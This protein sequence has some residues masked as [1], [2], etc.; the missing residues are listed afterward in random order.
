METISVAIITD[1]R[2]YGRALSLSI[3]SVC[4]NFM[5]DVFCKSREDCGAI[6]DSHDLVL[7]DGSDE[8]A[9]K[10]NLVFLTEKPSMVINDFSQKK[11]RIYKYA[12]AQSAVSSIFRIYSAMTGRRMVN[13]RSREVK[14][15]VFSSWSGG[16][17]CSTL[18]LATGQELS[19]FRGKK[20]MYLS[21]EELESTGDYFES[22]GGVR[23]A[24]RYLY[25][26]LKEKESQGQTSV[27]EPL[28]CSPFLEGYVLK[29]DFGMETFAPT[30]G[31]NPLKDVTT[32]ELY[33]LLSSLIDSGRYDVILMDLGNCLSKVSLSCIEMAERLCVVTAG[34]KEDS[35]E[36]RYF[37]HLI[38]SCGESVLEKTVRAVN[39]SPLRESGAEGDS[40]AGESAED[41]FVCGETLFIAKSPG[42]CMESGIRKISL[43]GAFG[44][45]IN[46]LA[47]SMTEPTDAE[48]TKEGP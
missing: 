33:L 19:R 47:K 16:A 27:M 26:L 3:L 11:Y 12:S 7:Y 43:E 10:S 45:S 30:R 44:E 21:F 14:L 46:R 32:E 25:H 31:R 1:D 2:E 9:G 28:R 35:R 13:V 48:Q 29:D 34:E 17:G 18:A 23:D 22:F 24:G 15:L 37:Q 40:A 4:K 42:F 36:I 20:V 6:C 39:M 41:P 38:Y 8:A 5:M